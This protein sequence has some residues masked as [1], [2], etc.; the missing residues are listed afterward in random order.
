[1]TFMILNSGSRLL[2][3]VFLKLISRSAICLHVAQC[4]VFSAVVKANS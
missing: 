2:V 4:L 1:M 3:Y